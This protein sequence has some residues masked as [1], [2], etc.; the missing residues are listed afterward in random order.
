MRV[1]E[2]GSGYGATA[3][4]LANAGN[5]VTAVEIS[6]RL[7]HRVPHDGPGT[8]EVVKRCGAT[9]PRISCC[10]WKAPAWH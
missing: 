1:L 8:V 6:D 4:A 7:A 5:A 10:C 3:A 2:L 9:H